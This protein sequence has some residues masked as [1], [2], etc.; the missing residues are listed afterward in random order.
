MCGIFGAAF[1]SRETSVDADSALRAIHVRGPDA[2]RVWRGPEATLGFVR[3]AILDLSDAGMQPMQSADGRATIV[4]NGEIYNHRELQKELEAKGHVFRSRC[5]TEVIV[6]GYRAWGDAIIERLDGMFA[7]AIY[8]EEQ[9]RLLLAR[10]RTGKKPLFYAHDGDGIRFASQISALVASGVPPEVDES[11]LPL[12]LSQGYVP[13]PDTMYKGVKQ[14]APGER[15]LFRPGRELERT[16][17]WQPPFAAPPLTDSLETALRRTRELF[18]AAVERRLE[19]DVPLGAFL[20]GGVDSTLVVGVMS[21][22]LGRKVKT[23][24]IG[25]AGDPRFDETKYA[26]LAAARFGTEHTEFE[27]EPSSF[28]L[29]ARLV[30]MHD[31]P[32]G[33]SSAIPTSVVSMLTRKHVT[34]A[35]TGDGGDELFCGYTRFLAAEAAERI[36][37]PL[38]AVGAV[39]SRFMPEGNGVK[40]KR[41]RAKRF[42]SKASLPLADRLTAWITYFTFELDQLLRPEIAARLDLGQS[43][44]WNREIV[45]ASAGASPLART[46]DHNFRTYLPYDLLVKADRSS[47]LHSLELRSPFLDTQL[48]EYAA[49]LPDRWKRRGTDTKWILKEAFA[50]VLP[51]EIRH[52]SKMGFGMPLGT[53]FRGALRPYLLDHFG[54]HARLYEWVQRPFVER[55]LEEHF[56]G[57]ADHG[58]RVWLLLTLELWLRQLA[59]E[60]TAVIPN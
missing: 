22:L 48:V 28:D 39:A 14:L 31:G 45:A 20:S 1:V 11:S 36:P 10:D 49:R 26:R 50:D 46:L 5:D 23:F 15:A 25:F 8:D 47:M 24:S 44:R 21:R 27:L 57:K 19:A 41:A 16:V 29:V 53:W 55:M 37:A 18:E 9:R 12:L 43:L 40:S 35:L 30:A 7:L 32:F 51:D 42:L 58:H 56:S 34:V 3:L 52:R 2:S 13:A 60:T 4:F 6:E 54:A 17:F 33:D 59:G 38:R